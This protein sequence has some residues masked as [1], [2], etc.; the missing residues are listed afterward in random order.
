MAMITFVN[1]ILRRVPPV[2][3]NFLCTF[4]LSSS[5]FVPEHDPV[6][7]EDIEKLE[8]FLADKPNILVLT[9]AGIS[10]ESGEWE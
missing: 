4:R 7:G 6:S 2:P 10:T 8:N 3:P 1:H 9:G 5:Q